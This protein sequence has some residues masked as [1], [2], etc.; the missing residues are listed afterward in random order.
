MPAAAQITELIAEK[1]PPGTYRATHFSPLRGA[2]LQADTD[3]SR[4]GRVSG[5]GSGE[6][7]DVP[8]G[9]FFVQAGRTVC[10]ALE[11]DV[12]VPADE[13]A[14]GHAGRAL[15]AHGGSG[16]DQKPLPAAGAL[17]EKQEKRIQVTLEK[18]K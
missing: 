3:K 13:R 6:V 9:A 17:S 5:G 18:G 8:D 1:D 15:G 14:R 10:G 16:Q 12:Q 4:R 2:E 11:R 7:Q